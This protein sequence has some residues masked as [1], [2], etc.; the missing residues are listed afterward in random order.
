MKQ[1]MERYKSRIEEYIQSIANMEICEKNVN[2]MH[3]M[4]KCYDKIVDMFKD[5]DFN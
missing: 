4:L 2:L 5:E 3:S 1:L